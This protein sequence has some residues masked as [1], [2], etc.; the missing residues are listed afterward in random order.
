KRRWS[1]STTTPRNASTRGTSRR[2]SN[3][4]LDGVDVVR[5]DVVALVTLEHGR[6]PFRDP[7]IL[8]DRLAHGVGELRG[9]GRREAHHAFAVAG[10]LARRADADRGVR[11]DQVPV[12][13][14]YVADDVDR[15]VV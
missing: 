14:V 9:M 8:A 4:P 12:T 7:R 5:H 6:Q 3:E 15:L 1:A 13:V 10:R 11:I 2:C